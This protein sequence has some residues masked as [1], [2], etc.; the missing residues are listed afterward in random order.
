MRLPSAVAALTGTLAL[1]AAGL[2]GAIS[3]V[4]MAN[5]ALD[6]PAG[7]AAGV[8]SGYWHT[9]AYSS[10][11]WVNDWVTLA[12]RYAG[13][14]TVI[15]FDLRNEPHTPAGDNYAKGATR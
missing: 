4:H 2:A 6:A 3:A 7:P 15:G 5:S 14:P 12:K 13:N 11:S 9:S 1:V 8:G 10:Q